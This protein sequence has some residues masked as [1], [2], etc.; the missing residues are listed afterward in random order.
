MRVVNGTRQNIFELGQSAAHVAVGERYQPGSNMG[1]V[2]TT[3]VS[4][5]ITIA[6]GIEIV[7]IEGSARLSLLCKTQFSIEQQR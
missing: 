1:N 2:N 3:D 6:A 5:P 4:H 7:L